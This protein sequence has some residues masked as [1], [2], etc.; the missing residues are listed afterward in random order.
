MKIETPR[1]VIQTN[2]K[3]KAELIWNSD[4]S[5]EKS[6]QFSNAQKIVDSEVLRRC[7]PYVPMQTGSLKR[8]GIL[9]T[10]VGSGIVEY[11]AP[12]AR[13]QYYTNSGNGRQGIN[14]HSRHNTTYC[15][16]GKLWFECMKANHK[17]EILRKA[18]EAVKW[19]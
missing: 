9:G 7:D 2:E 8:S 19:V 4:F 10:V 11:I 3:G 18:Q 15:L 6:K 13:R 12:Y 1:G 17:S 14:K 5:N 16:R